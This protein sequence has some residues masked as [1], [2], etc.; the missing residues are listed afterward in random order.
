MTPLKLF[1]QNNKKFQ[2]NDFKTKVLHC[3]LKSLVLHE[4]IVIS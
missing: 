2:E 3:Q 4:G 1:L